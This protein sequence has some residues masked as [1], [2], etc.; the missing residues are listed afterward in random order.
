MLIYSIVDPSAI[1]SS[2]IVT[3]FLTLG[4]IMISYL[5]LA[6]FLVACGTAFP[7][8]APLQT[9]YTRTPVHFVENTTESIGVQNTTCPYEVFGLFWT[10]GE[11]APSKSQLHSH[12]R[13]SVFIYIHPLHTMLS[14][15]FQRK[16]FKLKTLFFNILQC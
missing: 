14:S 6:A 8:G 11:F 4:H 9:C 13:S 15:V 3:G 12:F 5:I 7:V 2:F 1:L 16:E 10:P